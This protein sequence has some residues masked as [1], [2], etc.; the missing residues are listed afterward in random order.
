[1]QM[2]KW[3]PWTDTETAGGCSCTH[4][5]DG[6]RLLIDATDCPD[7]GELQSS[8][9]CRETV[10]AAI[11]DAQ[12]ERIIVATVGEKAAYL[13][14]AASLLAAAGQFASHVAIHDERLAA[15]A[16]RDPLDAAATAAGRAD[17]VRSI[18]AEVGLLDSAEGVGS[19]DDVLRPAVAPAVSDARIVRAPPPDARFVEQR[20]LSTGATVRVFERP[21]SLPLYHLEPLDVR[22]ETA[23][24]RALDRAAD[25]LAS[26]AVQGAGAARNA[27][28]RVVDDPAAAERVGTV[29]AKHTSDLGVLVDC[30]ADPAVTDVYATPPIPATPLRVEVDGERAET[31]LRLSAP[32][33]SAL[34][35]TFRLRSGRAFSRANPILDATARAGDREIRVAGTTEPVSDG[36]S[37]AIRAHEREPWT[38]D[39]LVANGTLPAA[40]AAL[41][42]VAVERDA[43]VLVSGPRGA[44]KTTLLGA[45][46]FELP[47]DVRTLLIEDTPELPV[48]TL[49]DAGRDVQTLHT[50]TDDGPGLPPAAVLRGALRLGDGALVVGEVRG[51][52]AGVL[53]EAMR[54]GASDNAVLGTIHGDRGDSVRER[55]VSDLGVAP[56]AFAATD[57]VVSLQSAGSNAAGGRRLGAIEEVID[58]ADGP[59]FSPLFDIRASTPGGSVQDD[60]ATQQ[61]D[62]DG[63]EVSGAVATG[64]IERGRSHLLEQLARP[65][66]PYAD[67]RAVIEARTSRFSDRS[68]THEWKS[69][70]EG[71]QP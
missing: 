64:R 9:G 50:E 60:P 26:G 21:D 23:E 16:R 47:K 6:D 44:G 2:R 24:L 56:S 43:A 31:N 45:L 25:L 39:R 8:P 3:L 49:R 32:G 48:E 27:A 67:V 15:S 53:Y 52:E 55:V 59:R 1:M 18:A 14:E 51:E 35:S 70:I 10:T 36:L 13:D 37:F 71:A 66:E 20:E 5:I 40:A 68:R 38:L 29:L 61:R 54:V 42:S 41:L 33:A 22:L 65:S 62:A 58:G 69:P 57:L 4:Q 46:L 28:E 63:S 11:G 12:V 17:P 30:F 7:D 19:Y 34:A